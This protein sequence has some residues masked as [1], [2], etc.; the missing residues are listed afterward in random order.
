MNK[1]TKLTWKYFFQQ[2]WKEIKFPVLV[3]LTAAITVII[4]LIV[5]FIGSKITWL[6][7]FAIVGNGDPDIC[8]SLGCF[9]AVGFL[10][11]TIILVIVFLIYYCWIW[12]DDNWQLAKKRA[13]RKLKDG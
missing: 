3:I 9:F 4:I 1:L 2:K 6:R 8:T 10:S 11:T 5:G 12:V 13:R 7:H